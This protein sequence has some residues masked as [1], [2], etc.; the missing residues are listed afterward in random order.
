MDS[1]LHAAYEAKYG[2]KVSARYKND[3]M[4]IKSKLEELKEDIAELEEAIEPQVEVKEEISIEKETP[5][6]VVIEKPQPRIATTKTL[7]ANQAISTVNNNLINSR[8]SYDRI[9]AWYGFTKQEA[10]LGDLEKYKLSE[11]EALVVSQYV[12]NQ[13][14]IGV[15]SNLNMAM[16]PDWVKPIVERH[17]LTTNDI[18]SAD[19]LDSKIMSSYLSQA[20]SLKQDIGPKEQADLQAKAKAEWDNVRNY[21][22]MLQND[23]KRKQK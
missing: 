6:E 16:F 14:K 13:T 15:L 5:K 12:Q 1:Q 4:W 10:F 19:T 18:L 9:Q 22:R 21:I 23:L 2:K 8:D 7:E 3:D 20:K 11:K 17:G